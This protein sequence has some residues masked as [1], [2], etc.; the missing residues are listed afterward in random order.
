MVNMDSKNK[1]NIPFPIIKHL[2]HPSV[3]LPVVHD[4]YKYD[5]NIN[6]VEKTE[7]ITRL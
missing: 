7:T 2:T 3:Q 6:R 1:S 4:V 5:L